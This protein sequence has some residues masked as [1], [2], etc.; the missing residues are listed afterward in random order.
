MKILPIFLGCIFFG[1]YLLAINPIQGF[2]WRFIFPIFPAFLLAL[3]YYFKDFKLDSLFKKR[4][5][6]L[7][8]IVLIFSVW[9]LRHIPSTLYEKKLR[10]QIDRVLVGKELAGLQGTMLISESGA[11]PYY[12]KW[13]AIDFLG[14]NSEEIAHKGLSIQIL[15]SINPDMI[16]LL[17]LSRDGR[18]QPFKVNEKLINNYMIEKGFIAVA[19]IHR[20]FGNYH[21]YFVRKSSMLFEKIV[22][23]LLK[24]DNVEYGNLDKQITEKRISI[25]ISDENIEKNSFPTNLY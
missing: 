3:V 23:R 1:C 20:S 7:L 6:L 24:I 4:K 2:L 25:Y 21:F 15:N 18:Y 16:M 13:K 5:I 19:S 10:T 14:L 12:S 22:E 17:S 11:L 8:V 9:T